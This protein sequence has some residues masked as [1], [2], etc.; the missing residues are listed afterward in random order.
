M[1]TPPAAT[2]PATE[3]RTV[4]I[5]SYLT[6]LGFVVAIIM[7]SSKKTQ[8]GAFHLR[9]ALGLFV[10]WFA[11]IILVF[12]PILGWIAMPIVAI[13]LFVFL[14]MGFIGAVQGTMKPVPI[15]GPYYQKWFAGAFN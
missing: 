12:I 4:A 13:C 10:T 3:D 15:L 1:D 6:L 8:L 7:H 2:P 14:I 11:T 9:Q 5:I